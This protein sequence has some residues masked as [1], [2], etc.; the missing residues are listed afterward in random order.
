M[1]K[2][3]KG[4]PNSTQVLRVLWQEG[5]FSK[6]K[7]LADISAHLSERGFNF[8]AG[9]LSMALKRASFLSKKGKRGHFSYLQIAPPSS[10]MGVRSG[11]FDQYDLHPKIK[12]VSLGQFQDGHFKEAIQNALVEVIEQVKQKTNNPTITTGNGRTKELD[13]DDLMQHVF[14]ADNGN[15]PKV[16]FNSLRTSL[17][18]TEQRGFLYLFKG[19]VGIRDKKAH[20][21]FI[22][23]DPIKTLEF[24]SLASLLLRL[25]DEH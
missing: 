24:L 15:T 1:S 23:K 8:Q 7:S 22:Q 9:G 17:D 10:P 5:F 14:G 18:R 4:V 19:I 20:L 3:N 16:A 21:N 13:G 2:G 11:L 25:L 12:E 6:A